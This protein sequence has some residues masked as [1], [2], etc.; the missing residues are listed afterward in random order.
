MYVLRNR[1]D[2]ERCLWTQPFLRIKQ[3]VVII[4]FFF[5]FLRLYLFFRERGREGEKH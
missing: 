4:S 5:F 3:F 1:G 2:F